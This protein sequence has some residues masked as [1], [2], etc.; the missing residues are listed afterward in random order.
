MYR[1]LKVAGIADFRDAGV[2]DNFTYWAS[3]PQTG[4]MA[5][6]VDFATSAVCTAMTR[7]SPGR[8]RAI[9]SI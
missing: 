6:H 9:R 1:N 7:T 5:A 3:L 2:V 8:V 4:D